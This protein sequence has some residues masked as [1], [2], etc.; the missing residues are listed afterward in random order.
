MVNK[1]ICRFAL[2]SVL[3][4]A[5]LLSSLAQKPPGSGKMPGYPEP[6]YPKPPVLRSVD[7]LMSIARHIVT[8]GKGLNMRPGYGIKGGEKVLFIV[9]DFTDP[10]VVEAFK[11]AFEEKNCKVDIFIQQSPFKG[12]WDTGDT[13]E[14]AVHAEKYAP[15]RK[16]PSL[17]EFA[18][19]QA[20]DIV[21]GRTFMTGE[22]GAQTDYGIRMM[23]PTRYTL[24]SPAETFPEEVLEAIEQKGWEM[25]R[26]ARR[27]H[28]TD[29]EGTDLSW[30]WS[31]EHWQVVEGSHPTYKIAIGG[32]THKFGPGESE[33]PII[34]GHLMAYPIGIIFEGA[35]AEGVIGGT[36]DHQGPFPYMK[37]RIV[38]NQI[39]SIEGGG[40]YGE[41]WREFLEKT[42]DIH[43]ISQPR[44]GADFVTEVSICT[45]PKIAR[46]FDVFHNRPGRSAWILDRM[47]SGV[48][49]IGIGINARRDWAAARG[50][51]TN[52]FHVHLYFPTVTIETRDGRTLTMI[53][54]GRLTA[55][56]D[57]DVRKVAAK[58]GNP[59]ELLRE[60]WIP[61]VPGINMD[62]DYMKNYAPDPAAFFKKDYERVYGDLIK[63]AVQQYGP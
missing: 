37:M 60:D 44:P 10:W 47:R 12:V 51:P 57:P 30:S 43:Y 25:V 32:L 11:R 26:Q 62:G 22:E 13:M 7:D 54:K 41:L 31:D 9:D 34:P 5:A 45:N 58:Y 48:I 36:T 23:W 6:R 4:P 14:R 3:L 61:G 29:P 42:K 56:D 38:K 19:G 1:L 2:L 35:D 55:L 21:V 20:Y 18:R 39:A 59:D 8:R 53:D 24:A 15:K 49:H 16:G 52:H 28:L 40:R 50:Y 27:V 46:P 63:Q 33:R 17:E